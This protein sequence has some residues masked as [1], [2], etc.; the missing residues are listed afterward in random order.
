MIERYI[1]D[2]FVA[3][4]CLV[5]LI[6]IFIRKVFE[7]DDFEY[8]KTHGRVAV[9]KFFFLLHG[10]ENLEIKGDIK[11][12]NTRRKIEAIRIQVLKYRVH[13]LPVL[14]ILSVM[15]SYIMS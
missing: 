8:A 1:F 14:I 7:F 12:I 5:V 11:N 13:Y 2:F 9:L 4:I 15:L 6:N 10:L 3:F